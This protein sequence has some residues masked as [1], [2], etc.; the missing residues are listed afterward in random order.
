MHREG[1]AGDRG[2]GPDGGEGRV[3]ARK[4]MALGVSGG[5]EF[6]TGSAAVV[7]R[8]RCLFTADPGVTLY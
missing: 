5:L 6:G 2:M 7:M 8:M 4:G 1:Q 3:G